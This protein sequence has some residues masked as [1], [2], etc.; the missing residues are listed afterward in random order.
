MAGQS[1]HI[2]QRLDDAADSARA[3]LVELGHRL[4][5]WITRAAEL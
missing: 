1:A 4:D 2:W 3:V 5:E